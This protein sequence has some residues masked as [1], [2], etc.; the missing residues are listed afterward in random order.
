M[1]FVQQRH[2][3]DILSPRLSVLIVPHRYSQNTSTVSEQ[4][5]L[6]NFWRITVFIWHMQIQ[7]NDVR[8]QSARLFQRLV[9]VPG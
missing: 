8:V 2:R 5:P 3:S 9:E 1:G 7:Q 6:H 4:R